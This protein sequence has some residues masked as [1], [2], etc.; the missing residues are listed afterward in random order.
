MGDG[1]WEG[2][3]NGIERGMGRR[4]VG[5]WVMGTWEGEGKVDG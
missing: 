2:E 5:G 1:P 4:G 3:E